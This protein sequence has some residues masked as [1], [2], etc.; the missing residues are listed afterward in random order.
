MKKHLLLFTLFI[1]FHAIAQHDS[2]YHYEE[3]GPL[4]WTDFTAPPIDGLDHN[5]TMFSGV[6]SAFFAPDSFDQ[7]ISTK[8]YMAYFNRVRSWQVKD[9][10]DS[11]SLAFYQVLYMCEIIHARQL[12]NIVPYTLS[13][14]KRTQRDSLQKDLE[15]QFY[16]EN[17]KREHRFSSEVRNFG[18]E[19]IWFWKDSLQQILDTLKN[20]NYYEYQ[21]NQPVIFH[22]YGFTGGSNFSGF[23]DYIPEIYLFHMRFGGNYKK[24]AMGLDIN[25]G[26]TTIKND[27]SDPKFSFSSAGN[28]TYAEMK[29]FY[30]YD[31]VYLPKWVIS[32]KLAAGYAALTYLE[33][34]AVAIDGP[35][36]FTGSL[37]LDIQYNF[38][39]KPISIFAGRDYYISLS[40]QYNFYQNLLPN[41]TGQGLSINLSIGYRLFDLNLTRYEYRS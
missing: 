9:E 33:P 11:S 37:S 35:I 20:P 5:G 18:N 36:A 39:T 14:S 8:H 6:Y 16:V 26:G 38:H 23:S 15:Q 21:K 29:L 31:L 41:Q 28:L 1:S 3:H 12:N 22:Q 30:G 7:K 2:T 27:Y 17:E 13:N 10:Q 25:F 4:E 19:R 40:S 34:E 24:A 32:P